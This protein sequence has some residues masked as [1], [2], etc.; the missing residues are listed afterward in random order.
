[1]L[2]FQKGPRLQVK[3]SGSGKL[4][5]LWTFHWEGQGCL[6]GAMET[7]SYEVRDTC[8][9]LLQMQCWVSLLGAQNGA[10]YLCFLP[11]LGPAGT[12]AAVAVAAARSLSTTS[13]SCALQEM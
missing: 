6:P 5:V 1:M 12:E 7:G 8:I 4:A 11:G 10:G 2:G 13:G 9:L 3:C